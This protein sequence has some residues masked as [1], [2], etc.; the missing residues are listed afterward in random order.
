MIYANSLK[1]DSLITID[2]TII[3][4]IYSYS[5]NSGLIFIQFVHLIGETNEN[6]PVLTVK[7][8]TFLN[9]NYLT[10]NTEYN[11]LI[12]LIDAKPGH[13]I[14]EN[15]T[16]NDI[17]S[18]EENL[19]RFEMIINLAKGSTA[20]SAVSSFINNIFAHYVKP[21]IIYEF[22]SANPKFIFTVDY[23]YLKVNSN[24]GYLSC[25]EYD[26]DYMEGIKTIGCAMIV[27]RE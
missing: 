13:F 25:T 3:Q 14:F 11:A 10:S 12:K 21:I 16:F 18:I 22:G 5:P 15:N 24:T 19:N 20:E 4:D 2:N 17:K 23:D 7:G 1:T 26:G 8:S 27:I 9:N 6:I